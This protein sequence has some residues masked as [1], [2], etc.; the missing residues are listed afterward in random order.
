MSCL[1]NDRYLKMRRP[2]KEVVRDREHLEPDEV[3]V[4]LAHAGD[5]GRHRE[6]DYAV[7]LLL[8]RHGLWA[9]ETA[10]LQ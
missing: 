2:L 7:L 10:V 5:R 3:M 4:L 1:T 8:C 6:R 9:Q